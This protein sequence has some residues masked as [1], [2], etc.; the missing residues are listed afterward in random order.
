M[1]PVFKRRRVSRNV[2]QR[3][4]D[5]ECVAVLYFE[6]I[7]ART[8]QEWTRQVS[9]CLRRNEF[10]VRLSCVVKLLSLISPQPSVSLKKIASI[11]VMF[12]CN[13]AK[14]ELPLRL[15]MVKIEGLAAFSK[16]RNKRKFFQAQ[17]SRVRNCGK[18]FTLSSSN[19]D[20][21]NRIF[22]LVLDTSHTRASV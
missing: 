7:A 16:V 2:A 11:S 22:Q 19:L 6:D 10:I 21:N 13:T 14:G 9:S 3:T 8:R 15:S 20:I 12:T 1:I 17:T 4:A 5:F 18:P